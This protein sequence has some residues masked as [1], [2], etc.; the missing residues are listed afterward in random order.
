MSVFKCVLKLL[1][2]SSCTERQYRGSINIKALLPLALMVA[3]HKFVD[4]STRENPI[5]VKV[6]GRPDTYLNQTFYHGK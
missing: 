1:S 5:K 4:N 6:F 2:L 3:L